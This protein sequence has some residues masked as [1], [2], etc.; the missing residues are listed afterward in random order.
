MTDKPD[1]PHLLI[2]KMTAQLLIAIAEN[3]DQ[4]QPDAKSVLRDAFA[5][6]RL[7]A[8]IDVYKGALHGWC[9]PDS[10]VYNQDQAERAWSELLMLFK[11]ALV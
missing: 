5:K 10:Q 1:S 7:R 9:P 3:D 4:K 2:P 11:A 8:E 6:A